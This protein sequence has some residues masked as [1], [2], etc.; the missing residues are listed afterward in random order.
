LYLPHI[1][2]EARL[3]ELAAM[4]GE[5]ICTQVRESYA[6]HEGTRCVGVH[7]GRWPDAARLAAMAGCLGGAALAAICR[8]YAEDFQGW[9][10]GMPDL[11]L[12]RVHGATA[13]AAGAPFGEAR[14]VRGRGS[15]R[16]IVR[17]RVRVWVRGW[18]RARAR[19]RARARVPLAMSLL[20]PRLVTKHLIQ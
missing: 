13:R 17:V 19:A 15:G 2:L 1:S 9:C 10:G 14:L 18:V 16:V 3:A 11:L 8:A 20:R 5:E 7:W 12:W 4:G 6:A